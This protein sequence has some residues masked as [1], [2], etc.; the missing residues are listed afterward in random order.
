MPGSPLYTLPN[1]ILTPHIAG[2]VKENTLRQGRQVT[3][4]IEAFVNGKALFGEL[5]LTHHDRLA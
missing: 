4:Q 3:E 1:C 5:D 2:A